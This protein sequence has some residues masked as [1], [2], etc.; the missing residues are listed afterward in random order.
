MDRTDGW[1]SRRA[2]ILALTVGFAFPVGFLATYPSE[3]EGGFEG[4]MEMIIVFVSVPIS[5][6]MVLLAVALNM[7]KP[8]VRWPAAFSFYM[9]GGLAGRQLVVGDTREGDFLLYL[10]VLF[11]ACVVALVLLLL[12]LTGREFRSDGRPVF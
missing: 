10:A 12:P 3:R 8:W 5:A 1:R 9:G 4:I 6:W 7:R 2:A 11:V